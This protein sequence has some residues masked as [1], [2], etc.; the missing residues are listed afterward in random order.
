MSRRRS[1]RSQD[2][3]ISEVE[4]DRRIRNLIRLGYIERVSDVPEDAIP[5][6]TTVPANSYYSLPMPLY[7]RED[8]S[9]RDCGKKVVWTPEE[10]FRYYEVEKG[11]MYARRVRCDSC[12]AKTT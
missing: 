7:T 8:Y 11:N 3:P 1:E 2:S 4:R 5:A 10:K 6:Q 9:C 12:H